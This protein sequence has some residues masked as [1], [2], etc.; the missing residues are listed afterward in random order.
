[1]I[2]YAIITESENSVD[3]TGVWS[4]CNPVN[5]KKTKRVAKEWKES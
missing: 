2:T 5:Q 1:M 3:L 4:E